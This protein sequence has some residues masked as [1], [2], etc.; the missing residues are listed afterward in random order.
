MVLKK[1][2]LKNKNM[3]L[4]KKISFSLI[5]IVFSLTL[6]AQQPS[7]TDYYK[8]QNMY[9]ENEFLMGF[10]SGI[11]T[12][13]EES[14]KLKSIYESLAKDKLIQ[15]IQVEIESN[16]SLNISNV[17]GKSDEEFLSKSVSFSSANV[18]GLSTQS[19]YNRKKKEV[20]A[21]AYVNRKELAFFYRNLI[22]SGQENIKQKLVEGRHYIK[23]NDKENALRSFYEAMPSLNSID[24]ARVLLIALNRKMYA[25]INMDEI[26]KLKVDLINE[27]NSLAK[28]SDLNL[29]ES[30]YFVAYGIFLQLGNVDDALFVDNFT[31]ENT[32]L[33]STFT[34]KWDDELSS[35][36]V[37][38]GN[39]KIDK[40]ENLEN[41]III[42]GNYW[43]EAELIKVN[44]SAIRYKKVIAASK[45]SIPINWL[46][47]ENIEYMPL[48]I[49]KMEFL[50]N[51]K[52][53]LVEVPK[54]IKLG[55]HTV[56]PIKV[57]VINIVSNT[58]VVGIPI[59]I[60]NKENSKKL[61]SSPSNQFGVSTCFLPSIK[62]EKPILNLEISVDLCDYLNIEEKSIF[63]SIAINNN[64]VE[65]LMLNIKTEK[66]T[67]FINS[68]ER[69]QGK[70]IS[71]K[72][73]EP[74]VKQVLAQKGY[75]FVDQAKN[76]DLI[77]N[78]KANTT[79]ASKY[80]GIYFS[81]LDANIS[82]IETSSGEEI[83]K[84]HLD[85][86]KGGGN[87]FEKAG[88]KA[89][90][91]AAKQIKETFLNNNFK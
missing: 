64:P 32:G 28:P 58:E 21:I 34:E 87:D 76:A 81:Y 43:N 53:E 40:T 33:K 69:N 1:S 48:E 3:L 60:L 90:I 16:N 85:Q 55:M 30:A 35:A 66:P 42:K 91:T 36:L 13:D 27:I 50:K 24:E 73:L 84:T 74:S 9:P 31:F 75:N 56:K 41:S 65:T 22:K 70:N 46:N 88:K 7:W 62:T 89:Y 10:V 23:K 83:Y 44:A 61:C 38:V 45:G 39:Y 82:I 12:T 67:I 72:T 29:S 18:S 17:N 79:S 26:N 19:F 51:Y 78:I 5:F 20:F 2:I 80:Q 47:T 86:I 25:D 59:N 68:E 15:S 77:I 4:F 11:N 63:Y 49:K 57:K 71:I 14:G 52:L 6:F 37:K 8:R 54:S